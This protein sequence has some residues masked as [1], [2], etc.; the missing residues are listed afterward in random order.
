M[1]ANNDSVFTCSCAPTT[2]Q[3]KHVIAM[4][5]IGPLCD[6]LEVRDT[7][8]IEIALDALDN[9]LRVGLV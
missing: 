2:Q 5:A 3:I 6:I 1:R 9:I 8:V 7:K 4:G